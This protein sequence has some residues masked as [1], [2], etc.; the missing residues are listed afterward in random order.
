MPQKEIAHQKENLAGG[1]GG[2]EMEKIPE[3]KENAEKHPISLSL[4]CRYSS[5]GAMGM[6]NPEGVL[7]FS[8][9]A[10]GPC[11]PIPLFVVRTE[12]ILG[13]FLNVMSCRAWSSNRETLCWQKDQAA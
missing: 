7:I 13:G 9:I 8:P 6:L 12:G 10:T 2:K 3:D 4:T 5:S 11:P 1:R